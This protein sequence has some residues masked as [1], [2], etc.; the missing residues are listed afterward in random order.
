MAHRSSA[1]L[2]MTTRMQQ[3][4]LA[5]VA[6]RPV[7]SLAI[8]LLFPFLLVLPATGCDVPISLDGPSDLGPGTNSGVIGPSGGSLSWCDGATLLIPPG[9]LSNEVT[10]TLEA[11]S[12]RGVPGYE[13]ASRE[14]SAAPTGLRLSTPATLAFPTST[15]EAG[16]VTAYWSP[17]GAPD[18]YQEIGGVQVGDRFIA[19]ENVF[20]TVFIGRACSTRSLSCASFSPYC[21]GP[22][23]LESPPGACSAGR[24][25]GTSS[26]CPRGC[27]AGSCL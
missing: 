11:A 15:D 26:V 10:V 16:K 22:Y 20:G 7:W 9:A 3:L 17:D 18:T 21:S 8:P 5:G 4:N 1:P 13:A 27:D 14:C 2:F 6:R 25:I 19:R 23:S 12:L 24:C